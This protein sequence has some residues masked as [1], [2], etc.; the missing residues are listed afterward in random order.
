MYTLNLI[1]VFFL[2]WMVGMTKGV[3]LSHV[4]SVFFC[5]RLYDSDTALGVSL[6]EYIGNGKQLETY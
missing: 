3:P 5:M 4:Q 1:F 2:F 6:G